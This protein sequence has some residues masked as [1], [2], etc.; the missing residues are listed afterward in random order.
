VRFGEMHIFPDGSYCGINPISI[1]EVNFSI[2]IEQPNRHSRDDLI[3]QLNQRIDQSK[4][5]KLLFDPIKIDTAALTSEEFR[6]TKIKTSFPIT[7]KN[8]IIAKNRIVSVGDASGFIDPMT[9]EG[10]TQ[11]LISSELLVK[12][13]VQFPDV[14]RALDHYR[15]SKVRYFRTKSLLNRSFQ[16]LI[17]HPHLVSMVSLIL[18]HN[19]RMSDTLM[20]IIGNLEKP[21]PGLCKLF[22]LFF[23]GLTLTK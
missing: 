8:P 17:Q 11:S 3:H 16:K 9:G 19:Q 2:V 4:R 13:L 1:D 22:L 12:S 6:D 21:L 10:I 5:L 20:R 23:R 18:S 15:K 7:H 14:D